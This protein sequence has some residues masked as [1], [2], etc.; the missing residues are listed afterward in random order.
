MFRRGGVSDAV[1]DCINQRREEVTFP[2]VAAF[3]GGCEPSPGCAWNRTPPQGSCSWHSFCTEHPFP[4]AQIISVILPVNSFPIPSEGAALPSSVPHQ[5]AVGT[6]TR[7]SS[8]GLC[9]YSV[10]LSHTLTTCHAL[11]FVDLFLTSTAA[12]TNPDASL[13]L[14]K[15]RSHYLNE[16]PDGEQT[17]AWS[18]EWGKGLRVQTYLQ[19]LPRLT[20]IA[21]ISPGCFI[22][23]KLDTRSL[24]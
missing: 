15:Y 4:L 13:L 11:S 12:A 2:T 17:C 1:E 16:R 14:D 22:Q 5:A 18:V 19:M 10:Y 7:P 20:G 3:P 6:S 24:Y 21:G 9:F 8:G 23:S